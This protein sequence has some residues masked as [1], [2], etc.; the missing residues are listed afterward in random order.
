MLV[1]AITGF[2]NTAAS[3][4]ITTAVAA[5]SNASIAVSGGVVSGY[6]MI[7]DFNAAENTI[8]LGGS[9]ALV[10]VAAASATAGANVKIASTGGVATFAAADD[11]LAEIVAT[12]VADTTN[13]TNDEVVV[14]EFGEN[15]YV[16]GA[17]GTAGGTTDYM[18]ELTGVTDLGTAAISSGELS[19]S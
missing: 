3:G 15:T 18:I 2:A 5:N 19:F 4:S 13:V 7:T 10:G 1:L 14:F 11:T 17:G 16:Y 6:D 9:N 8:L 12:L